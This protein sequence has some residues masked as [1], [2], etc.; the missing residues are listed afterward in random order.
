V[1]ALWKAFLAARRTLHDAP[2]RR[3]EVQRAASRVRLQIL[4]DDTDPSAWMRAATERARHGLEQPDLTALLARLGSPD[5]LDLTEAVRSALSLS[6]TMIVLGGTPDRTQGARV[7][8]HVFL[9]ELA[10]PIPADPQ[11]SSAAAGEI[12]ARAMRAVGGERRLAAV[13]GY[14]GRLRREGPLGPPIDETLWFS[15]DRLRRM[16]GVLATVIETVVGP[17]G[18]TERAGSETLALSAAECES[19]RQAAARHPLMLLAEHA[20]GATA[21]T[22]VSIRRIE[23]REIAVLERLDPARER[24]RLHIDAESGLVRAVEADEWREGIGR[25]HV[26]E[27][28]GDYR[29]VEG[30]RAPF[31]ITVI[32][33]DGGAPLHC[34]W[35]E[36]TLQTPPETALR[37]GGPRAVR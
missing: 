5:E 22:L 25:V 7:L 6:S 19:L 20:R 17:E 33:D 31:F 13:R 3:D 34:E 9:D 23:D 36:L 26:R 14:A 27:E 1:P 8:E 12:L 32:V 30:L 2:P 37:A 15:G 18:G 29:S 35:R 10:S 4:A 16:Q 28:I 24:L 21:W 11:A